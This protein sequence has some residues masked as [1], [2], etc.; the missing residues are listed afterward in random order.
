MELSALRV[1]GTVAMGPPAIQEVEDQ[2]PPAHS[3]ANPR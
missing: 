1:I 3:K 2:A